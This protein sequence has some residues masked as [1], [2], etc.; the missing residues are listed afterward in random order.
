MWPVRRHLRQNDIT[1]TFITPRARHRIKS[2]YHPREVLEIRRSSSEQQPTTYVTEILY[3]S[4]QASPR[5]L[6]PVTCHRTLEKPQVFSYK[7]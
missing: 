5:V 6:T 1:L 4:Y 7:F 2:V 3:T